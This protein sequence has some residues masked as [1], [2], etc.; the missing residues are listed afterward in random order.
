MSEYIKSTRTVGLDI[1]LRNISKVLGEIVEVLKDIEDDL[2]RS[3]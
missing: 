2:N 1:E 3:I